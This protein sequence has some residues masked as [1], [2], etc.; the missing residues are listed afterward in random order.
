MYH[1]L[2]QWKCIVSPFRGP[3]IPVKV[4]KASSSWRLWGRNC[5]VSVLASVVCTKAFP[6]LGSGTHCSDPSLHIHLLSSPWS[7]SPLLFLT[8]TPAVDLI[9]YNAV[10]THVHPSFHQPKFY[11]KIQSHSQ[12]AGGLNLGSG[13]TVPSITDRN[14]FFTGKCYRAIPP[15]VSSY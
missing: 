4:W 14:S 5:S 13:C 6:A 9:E 15:A 7:C 12:I 8:R 10:W 2:Q 3:Q 1:G 11:F